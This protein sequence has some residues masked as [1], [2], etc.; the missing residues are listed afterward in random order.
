[1]GKK[2]PVTFVC[3]TVLSLSLIGIPP[4]GGFFSK[5]HLASA[6]L[7]NNEIGI[8]SWIIPVILL[9]S[10]LLTAAYL[11]SIVIKGFWGKCSEVSDEKTVPEPKLMII[12]LILL[13]GFALL[14]G[15]FSQE[16]GNI[17]STIATSI[18]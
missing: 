1:M 4:T 5:W 18:F 16:T 12:P 15:I 11:L 9:I 6:A 14:G 17:L 2:M 3:F 8:L 7:N 10:A 13:A